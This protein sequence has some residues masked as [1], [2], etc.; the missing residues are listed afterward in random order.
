MEQQKN[1]ALVETPAFAEEEIS[2][3]TLPREQELVS[4]EINDIISHKPHWIVHH[5]ASFIGLI[6]L[7]MLVFSWFI[8]YPDVLKVPMDIV[9]LHSPKKIMARSEGKLQMLL[10][11]NGASVEARQPLAF[12]QSTGNHRDVLGIR[13]WIDTVETLTAKVG[14]HAIRS[15]RLPDKI[16]LGELQQSYLEFQT[17]YS[18]TLQTFA[19]GFYQQKLEALAMDISFIEDQNRILL[20][21]KQLL[22]EDYAIQKNEYT[23]K[24]QLAREKVIAPLEFGQDKSK[25]ISKSSEIQQMETQ[26]LSQKVTLHNKQKE[27]MELKKQ[28]SDLQ[29]KFYTSLLVFKSNVEEW[30]ARYVAVSPESG[31]LQFVSA[32]QENQHIAIDQQLFYV[33]PANSLFYGNISARQAGLGKVKVGQDVVI[34]VESY[35]SAEFGYLKGKISFI[36]PLLVKDSSFLIHVQLPDGMYTNYNKV[37][38]FRDNLKAS[39]EIITQ[40]R[41]LL[42]KLFSNVI[43]KARQ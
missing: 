30:I 29:S 39:A 23:M 22:E 2:V 38:P 8:H 41:R 6:A 4:D 37:I 42:E 24:A 9:A 3:D 32:L 21:Q 5:S 10:V 34:R 14:L 26:L 35:P 40:D 20:K 31:K 1:V 33:E 16:S 15:F 11:E 18:E 25:F 27:V 12:L 36:S 43:D 17:V 19:G 28:I 7:G 13:Q